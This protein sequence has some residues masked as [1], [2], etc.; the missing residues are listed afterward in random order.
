VDDTISYDNI[1]QRQLHL[2]WTAYQSSDS[3]P[4]LVL[5]GTVAREA[6][7]VDVFGEAQYTRVL[8]MDVKGLED[9]GAVEEA[10]DHPAYGQYSGGFTPYWLTDKG[11]HMLVDGGYPIDS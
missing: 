8:D 6:G 5:D 3:K 4:A 11:R 10:T 9:D 7:Y 2:L 1:K